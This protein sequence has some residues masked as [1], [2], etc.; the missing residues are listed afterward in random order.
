MWWIIIQ[1]GLLWIV[2]FL[3]LHFYCPYL[4]L[5]FLS[6]S[7][8][9]PFFMGHSKSLLFFPVL[10]NQFSSLFLADNFS[11]HFF[12]KIRDI[13][14]EIHYLA[15][16]KIYLFL[17]PAS[18]LSLL[19]EKRCLWRKKEDKDQPLSITWTPTFPRMI[20]TSSSLPPSASNRQAQMLPIL[21]KSSPAFTLLFSHCLV[22]PLHW[23]PSGRAWFQSCLDFP[24]CLK[25]S[26]SKSIIWL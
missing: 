23:W 11:S 24:H 12:E 14:Y 22:S 1:I 6:A 15:F 2:I 25:H 19:S 4:I 5:C 3:I 21:L 7:Y 18:T 20:I 10:Q 13:N 9:F 8:R 26:S 17:C 16:S